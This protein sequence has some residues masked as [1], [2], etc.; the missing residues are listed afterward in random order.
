MLSRGGTD[1]LRKLHCWNSRNGQGLAL[2]DASW[3]RISDAYPVVMIRRGDAQAT[4]SLNSH[5]T[6]NDVTS[7][8]FQNDLK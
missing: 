4:Q 5:A 2:Q 3:A 8:F 7:L 1:K 6:G